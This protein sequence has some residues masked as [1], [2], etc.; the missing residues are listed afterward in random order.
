MDTVAPEV[1]GKG[2]SRLGINARRAISIL[3]IVLFWSAAVPSPSMSAEAYAAAMDSL[4]QKTLKDL[5]AQLVREYGDMRCLDVVDTVVVLEEKLRDRR[6]LEWA[7]A[8]SYEGR[9]YLRLTDGPIRP[10]VKQE[11]LTKSITAMRA[12]NVVFSRLPQKTGVISHLII[13]QVYIADVFLR[14]EDAMN[15]ESI[16]RQ[17]EEMLNAASD[18]VEKRSDIGRTS[19]AG[20]VAMKSGDYFFATAMRTAEP[21]KKSQLLRSALKEYRKST[22]HDYGKQQPEYAT[23]I[24]GRT[25]AV[26]E[27]LG[28]LQGDEGYYRQ[29]ISSYRA[30]LNVPGRSPNFLADLNTNLR[31]L[32][33]HMK[34]MFASIRS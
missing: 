5:Q 24:H 7:V 8:K 25:A 12:A 19:L 33:L 34:A 17:A 16:Y 13:N 29:A 27:S 26:L 15:A 1:R 9:C 20:F 31:M 22:S 23:W 21:M 2:L 3:C 4:R 32:V 11:L 14:L 18:L 6:S 30:M 10:Q 28:S